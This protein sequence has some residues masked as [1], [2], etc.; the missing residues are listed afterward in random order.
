MEAKATG[1]ILFQD[2]RIGGHPPPFKS[3]DLLPTSLISRLL[4]AYAIL[5][6]RDSMELSGYVSNYRNARQNFYKW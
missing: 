4:Y 3:S 6:G 1:E 2:P 5:G